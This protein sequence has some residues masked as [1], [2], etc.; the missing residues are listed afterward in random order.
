M[1]MGGPNP[2]A[3]APAPPNPPA[4]APAV[5][6]QLPG[7][8]AWW[9]GGDGFRFLLQVFT[10][11]FLLAAL[12]LII[13]LFVRGN[14]NLA[15][16]PEAQGLIAGV[17]LM[18]I[19]VIELVAIMTALFGGSKDITLKDR[20]QM[21]RDVLAPLLAIFGTITGFYFGTK[22]TEKDGTT[23]KAPP[24]PGPQGGQYQNTK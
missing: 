20:I 16:V 13:A 7:S 1:A 8:R 2:P 11:L 10:L 17:L 6:H 12:I 15:Q 14:I 9:L 21:V 18:T 4:H 22:A 5:A 24:N 3:A 23:V 19:V